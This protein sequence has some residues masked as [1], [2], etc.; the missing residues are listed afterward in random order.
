MKRLSEGTGIRHFSPGQSLGSQ[1]MNDLNS[2][3]NH[4]TDLRIH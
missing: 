4:N 1:T 3:I 2:A